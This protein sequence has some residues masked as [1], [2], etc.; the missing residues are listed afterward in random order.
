MSRFVGHLICLSLASGITSNLKYAT[1]SWY[2]TQSNEVINIQELRWCRTYRHARAG[3]TLISFKVN[4]WSKYM[5]TFESYYCHTEFQEHI[6]KTFNVQLKV[7]F[8]RGLF[9][10][11]TKIIENSHSWKCIV[12]GD[13]ALTITVTNFSYMII[14]SLLLF[15][16]TS[17]SCFYTFYCHDPYS[18]YFF[19]IFMK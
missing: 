6:I 15:I 11:M 3:N 1:G 16:H 17:L 7:F 2:C 18:S 13:R 19:L 10:P 14:Q 8:L 12:R 5:R 4:M 9:T